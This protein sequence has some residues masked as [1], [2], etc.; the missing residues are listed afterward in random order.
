MNINEH[1]GTLMNINENEHEGRL[2]NL[3]FPPL[4]A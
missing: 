2:M 1:E 4:M 3:N